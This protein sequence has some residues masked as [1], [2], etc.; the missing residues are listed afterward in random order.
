LNIP[1]AMNPGA[2]IGCFVA[3]AL[4]PGIG[5]SEASIQTR[6]ISGGEV[7][8][9]EVEARYERQSV[10]VSGSGFEI[11]PHQTCGYV[12]IAF[13]DAKGRI[14]LRKDAEYRTSYWYAQSRRR[15]FS[16]SRLVRFSVNV[17]VS[18]AVA[19]VLVQ[20]RSTGGCEHSWSLNMPWTG[21]SISSF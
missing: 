11:F 15:A 13:L 14:V 10:S 16:Q 1:G 6:I 9:T 21:S 20:H 2:F 18:A 7:S 5:L 4:L 8:I 19:S 17:H 12:E 3:L